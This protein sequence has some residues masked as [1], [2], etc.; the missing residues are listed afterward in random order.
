VRLGLRLILIAPLLSVPFLCP[1]RAA[2]QLDPWE[3]EVYPYATE[4]RGMIEVE[5]DNAVVANGHSEGGEG[6]AAAEGG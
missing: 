3:F 1:T 2:A 6:T 5:S 4:G